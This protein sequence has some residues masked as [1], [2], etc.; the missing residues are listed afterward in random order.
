MQ[1]C[2]IEK[3]ISHNPKNRPNSKQL[4]AHPVFWS[5]AKTLQFLQ[6]V[7]DRIEKIEPD[8]PLLQ[9]LEKNANITIKNNWKTHICFELQSGLF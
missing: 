2:L 3:M 9:E 8:D 1:K 7:S 4:L 6:D 5:K